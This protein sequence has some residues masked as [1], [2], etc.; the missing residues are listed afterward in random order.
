M[1]QAWRDGNVSDAKVIEDQ[2]GSTRWGY[3][4]TVSHLLPV[5]HLL[6]GIDL[7]LT[8]FSSLVPVNRS[9]TSLLSSSRKVLLWH[10]LLRH[11]IHPHGAR[12]RYQT[13]R[14]L[15]LKVCLVDNQG[16]KRNRSRGKD[17]SR[18]RSDGMGRQLD[19]GPD[20]LVLGLCYRWPITIAPSGRTTLDASR[21]AA[22][23]DDEDD[24]E[25]V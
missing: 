7:A 20:R 6:L 15:Q 14:L 9:T 25:S 22:V 21:L 4:V 16:S 18:S 2:D 12:F 24:T 17:C 13:C 5:S 10:V 19:S 8:W 23:G 3:I 1:Y 11:S